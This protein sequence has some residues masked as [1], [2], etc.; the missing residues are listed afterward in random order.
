MS[1]GPSR[2]ARASSHEAGLAGTGLA[3]HHDDTAGPE[4][5]TELIELGVPTDERVPAHHRGG[6][7]LGRRRRRRPEVTGADGL[8][9]HRR[10]RERSHPQLLVDDA[11]ALPVLVDGGGSVAALGVQPHQGAVGGLVERVEVEPPLGV[12]D[13]LPRSPAAAKAVDEPST[14]AGHRPAQ[15]LG[16][17]RLP[18]VEV[19]AV[20]EPEAGQQIPSPQRRRPR[21]LLD[22]LRGH[23]REEVP[24]VD[25]DVVAID[26]L[27]LIPRDGR[28]EVAQL[29]LDHR[30]GAAEG[31][32]GAGVVRIGPQQGGQRLPAL[33]PR[34]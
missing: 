33:D 28:A 27:D 13:G 1:A 16:L 12:G 17:P 5:R 20:A 2:R 29:L 34:R 9:E 18:V 30:Q 23:P 6:G 4:G 19:G 11:H 7:G 21:D 25:R 32:A 26:E 10:L 14:R 24:D 31:A 22:V 8:V 3:L 15:P